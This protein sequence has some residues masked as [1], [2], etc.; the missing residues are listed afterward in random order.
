MVFKSPWPSLEPYTPMSVPEMMEA[1]VKRLPDKVALMTAE[2][3]AYTFQ[4]WW[5]AVKGMARAHMI[6]FLRALLY[7]TLPLLFVSAIAGI[8][9]LSLAQQLFS[10]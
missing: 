9:A 7:D 5:D 3:H 6:F 1:T 2:G 8:C 4:Q 10:N